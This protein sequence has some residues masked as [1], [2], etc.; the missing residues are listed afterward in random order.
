[1]SQDTKI[2]AKEAKELQFTDMLAQMNA[3]NKVQAIITV[4][5]LSLNL[6]KVMNIKPSGIS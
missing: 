5:L 2:S 3:I 6:N 1:M 4:Y